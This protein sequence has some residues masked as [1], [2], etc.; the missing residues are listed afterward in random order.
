MGFVGGHNVGDEYLGLN[1]K[2]GAWRDTHVRVEGP[3][4]TIEGVALRL[5]NPQAKQWSLNYASLRNGAM[6]QPVWGG[7]RDGRGEFFGQDSVDGKAIL[8]R[9]VITKIAKDAWRFEQ[10]YS[11]DGGRTWE[12]N[13]IAVD[14]LRKST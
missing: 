8:V 6:T 2:F 12:T 4:G 9:F 11:E 10:A 14:T 3:A 13:W 5:Y 1:P 7:F